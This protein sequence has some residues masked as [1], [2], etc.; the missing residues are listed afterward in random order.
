[1]SKMVFV[2]VCVLV[3]GL[4]FAKIEFVTFIRHI[5]AALSRFWFGQ[6]LSYLCRTTLARLLICLSHASAWLQTAL[7]H[8]TTTPPSSSR[9]LRSM[10]RVSQQANSRQSFS[11]AT[12]V[13]SV[14]P[15][16]LSTVLPQRRAFLQV[17][18][19]QSST[20]SKTII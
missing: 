7:F 20:S 16:T 11:L 17:F 13:L 9:S 15:T 5:S 8:H 18:I 12:S 2:Y 6:A 1:M 14:K 10:R 4:I 19:A 3:F